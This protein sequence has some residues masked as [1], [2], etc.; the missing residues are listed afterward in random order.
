MTS[1]HLRYPDSHHDSYSRTVFGFWLY[2]MT[3]CILFSVVFAV[4]AVLLHGTP[5]GPGPKELIHLPFVLAETLI[6]LAS[7]FAIALGMLPA[8]RGEVKKIVPWFVLT[9][10]LGAAFLG[11]EWKE[12]SDLLAAGY[13]WKK[14][15]FLSSYF[16][17]LATHGVH[18]FFGLLFMIV[19]VAQALKRGLTQT[20]LTRLTC[21]RLFW[22]FLDLVWIVMF[23]YVY[24]MGVV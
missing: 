22:L 19:F 4:Y 20:V 23:T 2:L 17:L 12:M 6:L 18:I 7:S 16:A 15:A 10:L 14:S 5:G 21:L 3:D 8:V 24:L 9:F 1:H 13:T 11:M